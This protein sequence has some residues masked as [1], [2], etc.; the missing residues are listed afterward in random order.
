MYKIFT[1]NSLVKKLYNWMKLMF[2]IRKWKNWKRNN[3]IWVCKV[4]GRWQVPW[5]R[6]WIGVSALNKYL[7]LTAKRQATVTAPKLVKT[8]QRENY[9]TIGQDTTRT[10]LHEG[11]NVIRSLFRW[12]P[13]LRSN[14]AAILNWCRHY[15]NCATIL[16]TN[17]FRYAFYPDIC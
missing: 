14:C 6:R 17:K 10:S 1:K 9:V 11:I 5:I 3:W 13:F 16:F 8:F 15:Q 4:V 2:F 12:P 7:H